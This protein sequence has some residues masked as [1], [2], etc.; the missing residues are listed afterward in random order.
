YRLACGLTV[1]SM[2]ETTSISLLIQWVRQG[3]GEA[4]LPVCLVESFKEDAFRMVRFEDFVPC[5]DVSLI[6]LNSFA[7]N[8]TARAFMEEMNHFIRGQMAG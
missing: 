8:M 1:S 6:H 2:I 4:L 3:L 5:W 7:W